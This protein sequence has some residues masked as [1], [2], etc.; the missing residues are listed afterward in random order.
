MKCRRRTSL[1]KLPTGCDGSDHQ[2]VY[3]TI[4]SYGET[5]AARGTTETMNIHRGSTGV[6]IWQSTCRH[7]YQYHFS[8]SRAKVPSCQV[9]YLIPIVLNFRFLAG[10]NGSAN[11]LTKINCMLPGYRLTDFEL[12][13]VDQLRFYDT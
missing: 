13:H 12:R 10:S 1:L 9:L 3:Q 4:I 6:K 2:R 11:W 7:N 5:I 8:L